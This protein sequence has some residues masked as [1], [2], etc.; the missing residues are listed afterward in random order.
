MKYKCKLKIYNNLDARFISSFGI[1]LKYKRDG[2]LFYKEA[3]LFYCTEIGE[4]YQKDETCYSFEEFIA[5][6]LGKFNNLSS[7]ELMKKIKNTIIK[8]E[9]IEN[10][11]TQV[12]NNLNNEISKLKQSTKGVFEIE[13]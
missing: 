4:E 12:K 11:E 3:T 8:K 2:T 10:K 1:D 9:G 13:I 7:E 5:T 6:K